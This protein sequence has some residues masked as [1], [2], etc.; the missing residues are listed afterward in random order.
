MWYFRK[1]TVYSVPGLFLVA[2]AIMYGIGFLAYIGVAVKRG[3]IVHHDD[4]TFMWINLIGFILTLQ[5]LF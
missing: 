1:H 5:A 4:F 2:M 3:R